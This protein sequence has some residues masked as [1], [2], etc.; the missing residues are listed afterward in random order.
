MDI[1]QIKKGMLVECQQGIGKVLV[2]DRETNCVLIEEQSSQQ[3]M[4]VDVQELIDNPQ[5]HQGC[6]QYY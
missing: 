2:V 3:Q 6:D 1:C 4:A 5:L